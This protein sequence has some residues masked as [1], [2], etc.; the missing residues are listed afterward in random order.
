MNDEGGVDDG[1]QGGVNRPIAEHFDIGHAEVADVVDGVRISGEHGGRDSLGDEV[2]EPSKNPADRRDGGPERPP[3]AVG[4]DA[5][6]AANGR[7]MN[8]AGKGV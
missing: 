3:A 1:V 4:L 8:R 7:W 6:H 2:D 5:V